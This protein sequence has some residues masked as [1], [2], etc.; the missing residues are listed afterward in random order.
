MFGKLLEHFKK[1]DW[2]KFC[3][4]GANNFFSETFCVRLDNPN[5]KG[6]FKDRFRKCDLW[7]V[8]F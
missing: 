2:K 6:I 3:E 7:K 8:Y 5:K 4:I 1:E